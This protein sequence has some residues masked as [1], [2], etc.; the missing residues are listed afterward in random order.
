MNRFILALLL[1]IAINPVFAGDWIS[2]QDNNCKIWND[3]PLPGETIRWSGKCLNGKAEGKGIVTWY[4]YA[5]LRSEH[6][7][8]YREGK[9][10][11]QGI[12]TWP[13]GHRYVGAYRDG[14]RN[15]FGE[16]TTSKSGYVA[17]ERSNLG[18]WVGDQFVERGIFKDNDFVRSCASEADCKKAELEESSKRERTAREACAQL[19]TG[20]AVAFEGEYATKAINTGVR[21][22]IT[23]IGREV[24]SA[25][26]TESI[27]EEMIGSV[28]EKSCTDFW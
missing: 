11:G 28:I 9:T 7:G 21:G 10:N 4:V 18:K 25:R 2:D 26:V 27:Y 15:G 13:G 19:Y 5:V 1:L 24:A 22:F 8:I 14:K 16:M 12:S 20:K 6:E 3:N 23:G 17:N